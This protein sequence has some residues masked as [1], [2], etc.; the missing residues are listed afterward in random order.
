LIG[1]PN[2]DGSFTCTLFAPFHNE[3]DPI[4]GAVI[5]GMR[6]IEDNPEAIRSYFAEYFPD[7]ISLM[8]DYVEAF[9]RNPSCPLVTVQVSPWNL[10][11]KMLL[12]GDAAHA[13]VP[14]YGQG[15]NAA[16]EDVYELVQE[17][18]AKNDNLSLAIPEFSAQ[19]QPAGAGIR[20]LSMNN[21]KEMAHHAGSPIFRARK[22]VE[23]W[24]HWLFPTKWIPLYKMVAFTSTPYHKAIQYA[25]QQDSR[26]GAGTFALIFATTLLGT[27]YAYDSFTAR[28]RQV[29]MTSIGH[30]VT[31]AAKK[32]FDPHWFYPTSGALLAGFI[33]RRAVME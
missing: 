23:G 21:Y 28:T 9:Q 2:A 6:D 1:L 7:V 17:I 32:C 33:A 4:T 13:V 16:F 30:A 18:E 22:R 26:F 11:S 14:F 24:L 12:I 10:G 3:V 8:P 31:D 29:A 27:R 20:T 19:R 25:E 5:P 15:M